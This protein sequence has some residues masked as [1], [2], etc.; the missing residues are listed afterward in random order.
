MKTLFCLTIVFTVF[1]A[2]QLCAGGGSGIESSTTAPEQSKLE[3]AVESAYLLG[4]INSPHSYEMGAEFITARMRWGVI[5]NDSWLRGYQ[6]VYFSAVAEPIFRGIEN[7]Y[8]GFN[9]GLRYNF[10]RPDSRFIPYASG[11]VGAGL[12]D[13]HASILG[14][15]GQDFTFN[16]L[17]AVGVSYRWNDRWK[18]DAGILYQHLSNGGQTD[19]NPSLNLI[20][21]QIGVIYSF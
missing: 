3:V 10:A 5:E 20:G 12:I 9:F 7:H 11:G 8:F 1:T 14:A 18:L 15:Q 2:S 16:I 6:Q 17:S 4:F 21:P 13:S 19:P